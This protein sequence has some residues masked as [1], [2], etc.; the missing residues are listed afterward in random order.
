MKRSLAILATLILVFVLNAQGQYTT[1]QQLPMT[2]M[3][4]ILR[5]VE[6]IPLPGNGYMDH[7]A[8]DV[9]GQ[10]L[11]VSG[12]AAKS[13][14][15]VDLR[16]GKVIHE[17]KGLS[18]MP[19][20]PF[21]LPDTDEVWTTLTDSS[22][23]AISGSTYEVIK[24]VKLSGYGDA[25]RGADNAAYDPANH[26]IYAGVEVFENFGGSGQHGSTDASIDIVDTKTATLVGSI[27]LPGGDPAGIA[28]EPSGKKLYVTM[29]ILW[30]AKVTLPSS[31][32]K[33]AR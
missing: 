5:L 31:I 14:I 27:K 16:A 12:E 25:N 6:T 30:T 20:K 18:A 21:Y 22:V 4:G 28:I 11:F 17:T 32:S 23:V 9:K 13:L 33:N 8:A 2:H 19:K 7:L 29:E 15:V 24:T 3:S 1:G 26:L 10:R